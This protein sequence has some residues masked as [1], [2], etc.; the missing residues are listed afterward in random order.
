MDVGELPVGFVGE[1]LMDGDLGVAVKSGMR[2][3]GSRASCR[4]E[5]KRPE[6]DE[7]VGRFGSSSVASSCGQNRSADGQRMR[8]RERKIWRPERRLGKALTR[9][10]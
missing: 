1:E 4:E 3:A 6:Y 7:V 10:I 5:G 8:T 2:S 9:R